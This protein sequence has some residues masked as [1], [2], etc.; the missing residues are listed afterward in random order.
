ML[1]AYEFLA[2]TGTRRSIS[3]LLLGE[4]MFELLLSAGVTNSRSCPGT[5]HMLMMLVMVA[6]LSLHFRGA[7]GTPDLS[8]ENCVGVSGHLVDMVDRT[9]LHVLR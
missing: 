9:W 2:G 8:L 7:R 6:L 5:T 4:L 3:D 1:S